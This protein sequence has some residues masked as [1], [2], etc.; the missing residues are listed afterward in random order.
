[1]FRAFKEVEEQELGGKQDM[2]ISE[3]GRELMLHAFGSNGP[4]TD[5]K[6]RQ[7][8]QDAMREFIRGGF[9]NVSGTPPDIVRS[10]LKTQLK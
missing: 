10:C 4:L 1:M 5:K 3:Y 6:A 7:G 8:E 2:A 9:H